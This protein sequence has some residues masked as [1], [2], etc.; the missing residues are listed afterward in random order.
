MPVAALSEITDRI[1]EVVGNHGLYAVF[2]LMMIDAVFP[3]ASELVMLYAGA[4]ASGAIAGQSVSLF[5]HEFQSGFPAFVAMATAGTLGYLVGSIA[6]WGAG[7]YLGRPWL[8]RHGRWLH[9]ERGEPRPGRA[10]VRPLGG[11]G[12]V[13]R[14][15]HA[16]DAL[17]HLDPGR[18]L[19][20]AL[21]AVRVADPA[22]LGDLV[23]RLCGRGL[24]GRGQLGEHRQ[25]LPLRRVRDRRGRRRGAR[26]PRMALGSAPPAARP[27][28]RHVRISLRRGGY[29]RPS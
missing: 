25:R 28:R 16:G 4:I 8:E 2:I 17:V 3:A 24:G 7:D 5:G 26:R 10:L 13:P 18:R 27:T 19:P 12:R 22:R 14:P 29:T 20:R 9:L 11:V 6:G 15:H 1:T 21:R 23:L